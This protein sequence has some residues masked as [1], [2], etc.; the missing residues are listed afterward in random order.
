[1]AL[2]AFDPRIKSEDMPSCPRQNH[3]FHRF[4]WF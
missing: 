2:A 1:V 4:R 3:G